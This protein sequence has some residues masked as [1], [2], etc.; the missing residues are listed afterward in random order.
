MKTF[1][2]IESL[3]MREDDKRNNE[4]FQTL[5]YCWL[6]D[7][8]DLSP[9]IPGLYDIK[10]MNERNFSPNFKMAQKELLDF[11]EVKNEFE[12]QLKKL[13]EEIYDPN[14]AFTQTQ[15]H[16]ICENCDFINICKRDA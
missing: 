3:F 6:Y 14:L 4:A 10:G 2:S 12:I 11:N 16:K 15:N 1:P 5:L 7:K 13:I 9:L 8:S